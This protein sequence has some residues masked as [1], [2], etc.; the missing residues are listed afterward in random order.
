MT[1][2]PDRPA[3]V[4]VRTGDGTPVPELTDALLTKILDEPRSPRDP[5]IE[6]ERGAHDYLRARLLPDGMYE[7]EYCAGDATEIFQ[8]YTSDARM[9]RD[10]MF[11][12]ID[13]NP[14]WRESVAWYRVDP[15]VEEVRSVLREFDDL[16][17][18][19]SVL[20]DIGSSMD[21]A[22]ARADELL[23][24]ADDPDDQADGRTS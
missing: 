9:L 1:D 18:G 2:D 12:W 6:L 13:E 15:A 7:L 17:G 4:H 23:A 3:D 10:V 16:L 20:D 22:L 5:S 11:A 14:W 21:D 19:L 24:D 8:M